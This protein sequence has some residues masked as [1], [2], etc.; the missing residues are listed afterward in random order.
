MNGASSWAYTGSASDS[1]RGYIAAQ[2]VRT[3]NCNGVR[4]R[5]QG[6][7]PPL[8]VHSHVAGQAPRLTGHIHVCFQQRLFGPR[9]DQPMAKCG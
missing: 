9:S 5:S 2:F 6:R 4:A 1:S 8:L 3:E 7:L